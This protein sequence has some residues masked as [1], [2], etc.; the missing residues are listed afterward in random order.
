[1]DQYRPDLALVHDLGFGFH[2]D[3]CA[4]GVLALLEPARAGRVLELGCGSGALTRHL[5][6]A[7]HDVVATDGSPAM[8]ELA[9]SRL[10]GADV[11]LLALPD[12]PLPVADAVVSTGHV[13]SYLPGEE[14]L[15]RAL[16]AAARA[17]RPGGVLALDLC[18]LRY[19]AA[20]AGAPPSTRVED[21]WALV[22]A[23]ETP[24]VDRFVRRIT[25]FVR[26]DDGRWRRDDERHE[27]VLVDAAALLPLLAAEGVDAEVRP[28]FGDEALP[29]GLV[30]LV[31]RKR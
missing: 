28:A 26:E 31:G 6:R 27:N 22:A 24:A 3:L 4:P 18:D 14:A 29:D 8:V 1:V 20:R 13:L 7:G 5:L 2:G 12:D 9:R 19:G 30:V 23:Y 16:V 15:R 17:L 10:P 25:T 11:R 21:G